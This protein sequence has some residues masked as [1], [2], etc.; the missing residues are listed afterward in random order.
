M[1]TLKLDVEQYLPLAR[2]VADSTAWRWSGVEA[3]EVFGELS[4]LLVAKAGYL[5]KAGNVDAAVRVALSGWATAYASAE[6]VR[7]LYGTSQY[8]YG[9]DETA[10]LLDHFFGAQGAWAEARLHETTDHRGSIFS[11]GGILDG[12]CDVSRAWETLPETDAVTLC[13]VHR[14]TGGDGPTRTDWATAAT[15]AGKTPKG[16]REAYRRALRK[17]TDRMNGSAASRR[18]AHEGPGA[19]RAIP[20][21]SAIARTGHTYQG[22]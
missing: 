4:L 3:D 11:P 12:L 6:R 10:L 17:L 8:H 19:R 5:A 1:T 7:A 21:G 16:L 20:N 22:E 14:H 18:N 13:L 2:K 9:T 15:E